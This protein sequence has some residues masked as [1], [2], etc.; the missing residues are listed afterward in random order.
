MLVTM[1]T[2]VSMTTG[3]TRD[4]EFYKFA[5]TV[6]YKF[7]AL[8]FAKHSFNIDSCFATATAIPGNIG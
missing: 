2:S 1:T 6:N 4:M 5:Q 7:F 8:A 3:H